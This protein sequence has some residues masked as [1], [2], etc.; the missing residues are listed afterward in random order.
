MNS[1]KGLTKKWHGLP[2]WAWAAVGAV[3]LYFGYRW[4]KNRTPAAAA[5]PAGTGTATVPTDQGTPDSGLG[6]LGGGDSGGG[7]GTFTPTQGDQPLTGSTPPEINI[8]NP[9]NVPT[10]PSNGPV[11]VPSGS[12]TTGKQAI[13]RKVATKVIPAKTGAAAKPQPR[14]SDV[15]TGV[16]PT[17]Y[18]AVPSKTPVTAKSTP[19]PVKIEAGSAAPSKKRAKPLTRNQANPNA[20]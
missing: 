14:A 10:I 16:G 5:N 20:T 1:L 18:G 19:V 8:F 6:G 9:G 3:V 13:T 17:G 2:L 12:N 11:P 7:G 4:Y 15:P